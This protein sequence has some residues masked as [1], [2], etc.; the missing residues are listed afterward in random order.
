[1]SD[2]E[3]REIFRIA[4]EVDYRIHE[5]LIVATLAILGFSIEQFD[6]Q[7]TP[8]FIWLVVISWLLLLLST[9]LGLNQILWRVALDGTQWNLGRH[10]E[11][12]EQM[13]KSPSLAGPAMELQKKVDEGRE[14]FKKNAR[15]TELKSQ[16]QL[17][18]LGLGVT[19]LVLF[20]C[21]NVI[22]S[23]QSP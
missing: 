7:R 1:M 23:I 2:F 8:Q 14:W 18:S 6:I 10:R 11:S 12:A 5:Y 17:W 9:L 4:K 15:R 3:R 13:S 21:L 19:G 16:V 22:S 20:K